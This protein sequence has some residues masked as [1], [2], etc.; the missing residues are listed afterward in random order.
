MSQSKKDQFRLE[1]SKDKTLMKIHEFYYNGWPEQSKVSANC[2]SFYPLRNSIYVEAGIVIV[3]EKV[4]VPVSVRMEMIKL[5]HKGHIGV[6]KTINK[7]R[8]LFYWP[9]LSNDV[10]AYIKK[11]RTCE[12]YMPSNFKEPLLPHS[13]PKYRFSKIATDILEFGNKCYLAVIDYFSHWLEIVELKDK[14]SKCVINA[15]QD[16]FITFGYPQHIIADN[17]P[18]ISSHCQKYYK[19]KDISISTCS[20]YYHQS[21]GLAEK[22]VSIGKQILRICSEDNVDYREC[23]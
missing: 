11:C 19:E 15:F 7:A 20:P 18:F 13:V 12:K 1:T 23:V 16:I 10:I 17:L 14:T 6:C 9:N 8:Q 21:N 5:L 22:A 3:D 4:V 2:K